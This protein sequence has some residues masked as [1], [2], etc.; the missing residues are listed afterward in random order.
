MIWLS[1]TNIVSDNK[2]HISILILRRVPCLIPT[3]VG[4]YLIFSAFPYFL[5]FSCFKFLRR[6]CGVCLFLVWCILTLRTKWFRASLICAI[7]VLCG[8]VQC[9]VRQF[10]TE[11]SKKYFRALSYLLPCSVPWRLFCG[12]VRAVSMC[13]NHPFNSSNPPHPQ[14]LKPP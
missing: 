2:K 7:K 10:F 13:A 14:L 9:G 12:V 8:V 11:S 1:L 4:G 6:L 5:L 3:W